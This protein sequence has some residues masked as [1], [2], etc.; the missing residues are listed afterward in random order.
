MEV[1][2]GLRR[3]TPTAAEQVCDAA[4]GREGGML[5]IRAD[6]RILFAQSS[7]R[8]K[9]NLQQS[10]GASYSSHWSTD[11]KGPDAKYSGLQ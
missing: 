7:R 6:Q 5:R 2:D 4:E 11:Y 8:T 3:A 9:G 1:M 10:A